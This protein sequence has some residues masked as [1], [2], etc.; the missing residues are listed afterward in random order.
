MASVRISPV[1]YLQGP[2]AKE[3]GEAEERGRQAPTGLSYTPSTRGSLARRP[4]EERGEQ[5]LNHHL[6]DLVK[7]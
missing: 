5:C 4:W 6:V 1:E 7:H 3:E 2:R